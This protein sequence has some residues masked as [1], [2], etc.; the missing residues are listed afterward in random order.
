MRRLLPLNTRC[1]FLE[2][3]PPNPLPNEPPPKTS[4]NWLKMSSMFMPPP[5]P[6]PPEA[7]P[8][9]A[10]PYW[11]YLAFLLPSLSTS[12]ASA[13]SL[14]FPSALLSSGFLSGWCFNAI[15]LYAFF[16]SSAEAFFAIPKIS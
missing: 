3:P 5:K 12:Y 1:L 16:I 6:P 7:P 2:L 15:F 14:N 4:P 13:A 11:S 9:P 8:K 10:C